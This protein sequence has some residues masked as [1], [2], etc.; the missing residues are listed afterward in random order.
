MLGLVLGDGFAG[1]SRTGS[2]REFDFKRKGGHE[3][4][5]KHIWAGVWGQAG[6]GFLRKRNTDRLGGAFGV[7]G[8]G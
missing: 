5:S 6:L 4:G 2:L 1:V 3:G 8:T 7:I